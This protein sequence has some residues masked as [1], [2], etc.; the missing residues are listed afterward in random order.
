[1]TAA[2][3]KIGQKVNLRTGTFMKGGVVT[4]I[5]EQYNRVYVNWPQH[6]SSSIP[7]TELVFA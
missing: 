3:F 7:A 5:N 4:G 2:S 6:G 1:M